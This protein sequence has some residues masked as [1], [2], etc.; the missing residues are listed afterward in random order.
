MKTKTDK[1]QE[2]L[3]KMNPHTAPK[4]FSHYC[5]KCEY[6]GRY[7]QYDLYFCPSER[8]GSLIARTG[9]W[10]GEYASTDA[11]LFLGL[12]TFSESDFELHQVF[13]EVYR[14]HM[15]KQTGAEIRHG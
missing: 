7:R 9:N 4:R 6:H 11:G 12:S 15:C 10:D 3:Y 14:R 5:K 13:R 1:Y 2:M 8:G